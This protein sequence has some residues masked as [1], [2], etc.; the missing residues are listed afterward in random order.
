[1]RQ[2]LFYSCNSDLL[3][4]ARA[5]LRQN[6]E[7]GAVVLAPT[8]GAAEDL[9]RGEALRGLTGIHTLTLNQLAALVAAPELGSRK[10]T[11]LSR[12]SQEA[13]VARVVHQARSESALR[14]FSP[15][16]DRP[17]FARAL[18]QTLSEL[19]L[20]GIAWRELRALGDGG[21]DLA[22]LAERY[23]LLLEEQ[24]L[25]D[26]AAILARACE[27][28]GR[29]TATHRLLELPLI[30][31]DVP[32]RDRATRTWARAVMEGERGVWIGV[33]EADAESVRV[34]REAA[35]VE[36]R[37]EPS[38]AGAATML[39]RL[40]AQLFAAEAEAG[41]ADATF[42]L[43]SA[44]GEG[45]ESAEIARRIHALADAGVAF[46]RIAIALRAP[47][48]YQPLIEEA[49]RRASI[50]AYFSGGTARP[51]ASGRAFLALL[52]CAMERCSATR[53]GEYLSLAQTPEGGVPV[54]ERA[55]AVGSQDELLSVL[56]P[57]ALVTAVTEEEPEPGPA[58]STPWAW[59]RLIVDA[60][61]VGGSARWERRL[62]GLE[63]EVRQQRKEADEEGEQRRLERRL[64]QLRA[65]KAFA[66]PLI[67]LLDTMPEQASWG[68]WIARFEELAE[69]ALRKPET[70]LSL[71]RELMP[72][73]E[74]GP[75]R[76][77][78]A[79]GVLEERL[80]FLRRDPPQRR[81]GKVFVGAPEELRGRTFEAVFVPGLA[82]GVFPRRV[83][84][85]PLLVDADRRRLS[86][87][88]ATR[89]DRVAR[90][91]LQLAM[92]VAAAAA[93][94]VASYP[95]IDAAQSRPRVP[96]FYALELERAAKGAL[97][98]LKVF[99]REA[100]S[101]APV[102]LGWPAPA[103]PAVALDDA[104]YDL[105]CYAQ[106]AAHPE[107]ERGLGRFIL[108]ANP[109]A[110][111]A[112][113]ARW[114]RWAKKWWD[115][116]GF[117]DPD[118]AAQAAL[119][120]NLLSERAYSP[121]SLQT[122]AACPYRFFL[123]GVQHLKPREESVALEQ[124]DPLTRGR[125]FHQVQ[126]EFVHEMGRK[127]P[128]TKAKLADALDCVDR[129]LD[130]VAASFEDDLAPAIPR[131]WASEVEEIRTD[132]RGW[133]RHLATV[134]S[135]WKPLEVEFGFG[136]EEARVSLGGYQVRGYVDLIERNTENGE[137]RITDHKT[138]RTPEKRFIYIGGGSVL[139][140]ILYA[141]A[142]EQLRGETVHRSRLFYC[143]Q[144]GEYREQEI[145][146][147][148]PG[149]KSV[150]DALETIEL[151]IAEGFLPAAPQ[152]DACG[153]CDYHAVC[154]PYEEQRVMRKDRTR[155]VRLDELR[156]MS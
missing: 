50:E 38:G 35:A 114:K 105:A 151:A 48:R 54:R 43:F 80:R 69:T 45:L 59:E 125:L 21:E 29:G 61:V 153:N 149:R 53:F 95:R 19:R 124:M 107:T 128:L 6:M 41:A 92:P 33:N 129:L 139:Q 142:V 22:W 46:D 47:E 74:V 120:K 8:R 81:Y 42:E 63:F 32:L 141:L 36:G 88:L 49:L 116:D 77:A 152:K 25:A 112:L 56:Q 31:C 147:N 44:P 67:S 99:E 155:L 109:A 20:G 37:S 62:T 93:K 134:D 1:M 126:E 146:L 127:M 115:A 82:E 101:A 26:L 4:A 78:E 148:A 118:E 156:R 94:L 135:D 79:Y 98:D 5:Q 91:R 86:S 72:M 70:V 68:V 27:V 121:T 133:L 71:L 64:A 3:A 138:G 122:Y 106:Y 11:P 75:V 140:P 12:L 7:R 104:E 28:A 39:E 111:R 2:L 15:V 87:G 24:R 89:D 76:L 23:G 73:R 132:L 123:Q 108:H 144:R 16:A 96:S 34:W 84:E 136:G 85:D 150:S 83:N 102:R 30:V 131:V 117:V 10:T 51:D 66:L 119:G 18:A 52:Q 55:M 40:R 58:V 90:E 65:L 145:P 130:R 154:G 13:L 17:G 60:A 143:T 100:A 110:G 103:D 57:G 113:R 97:P 137:L 14:Y 9:V